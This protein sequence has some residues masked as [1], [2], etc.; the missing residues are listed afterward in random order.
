MVATK[1]KN[2]I[3][4][5]DNKVNTSIT[6]REAAAN[7]DLFRKLQKIVMAMVKFSRKCG[8]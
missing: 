3:N 4:N 7:G 2:E 6:R 1:D 5:D 8:G